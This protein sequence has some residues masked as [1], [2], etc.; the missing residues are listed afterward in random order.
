VPIGALEFAEIGTTP[1]DRGIGNEP[2]AVPIGALEFSATGT[3]FGGAVPVGRKAVEFAG[4]LDLDMEPR[5][6]FSV[7]ENSGPEVLVGR[8]AE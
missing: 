7:F 4:V 1:V 2:E 3:V 5:R 8:N 6:G